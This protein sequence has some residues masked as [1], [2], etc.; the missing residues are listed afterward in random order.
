MHRT[1]TGNIGE[2]A[3]VLPENNCSL[4]IRQAK[5]L[6]KQPPRIPRIE[7]DSCITSRKRKFP[8]SMR[9]DGEWFEC[10]DGY[11][12]PVVRGLIL[13]ARGEW[14]PVP[15][16][17]DTGA[18]CTVIGAAILDVL[19]FG[20]RTSDNRLAGI[21][22]I[23]ESVKIHTQ[24]RLPRD[25]GGTATFRGEYAAFTQLETL[26]MSILGRDIMDMFAVIIDRPDDVVTLIRQHHRYAIQ[27]E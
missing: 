8:A 27:S 9:I 3:F 4:R 17:V 20:T 21:G 1:S 25:D 22:G 15:L 11:V 7:V 2:S 16:L 19:G 24:L 13:N 12:R 10:D 14:E 18:D 6:P 5:P 26:D 23:V